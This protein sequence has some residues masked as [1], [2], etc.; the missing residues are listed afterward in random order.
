MN[1]LARGAA[2]FCLVAAL[3]FFSFFFPYPRSR[4]TGKKLA[5]LIRARA[6]L[7]RDSDF[8]RAMFEAADWPSSTFFFLGSRCKRG[9]DERWME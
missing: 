7:F 5:E 8:A 1:V 2:Q 3:F 4:A 6:R 9:V